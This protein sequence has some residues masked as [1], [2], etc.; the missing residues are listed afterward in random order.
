MSIVITPGE[1]DLIKAFEDVG[2]EFIKENLLV[3]DAHIRKDGQTLYIFE[4]KAKGDLDASIKDG[5]YREQKGRMIESGVPR[6]NIIYVIEQLSRPRGPGADKRIWSAMCNSI[7]RDGFG[8]FQTKNVAETV[9]FLAS[10]AKSVEQFTAIEDSQDHTE[11]N[12]NIKKR[13]V[14]E[15]DWFKYSLTLIPKCSLVIAEVIVEKYPTIGALT[16]EIKENGNECLADLRHGA[17]KR[18]VG[19]ILSTKICSTLLGNF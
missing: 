1:T 19:G 12:V 17:S 5:R 2:I 13:Q 4:R 16:A 11:V 3:G 14:G 6:R 18:R 7:H 10:M 8:V 15:N 9:T